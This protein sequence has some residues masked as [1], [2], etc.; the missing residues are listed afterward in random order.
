[1]MD[2]KQSFLSFLMV[3]VLAFMLPMNALGAPGNDA[4]QEP[5]YAK[6]GRI[7]VQEVKA[8]YPEDKVVDYLHV[9]RKT[10]D[11]E[12]IETFKLWLEG[13]TKEFGVVIDIHFDTDTEKI[14]NI[15]FKETSR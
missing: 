13:K 4:P 7:A 9:G 15:Q 6:W 3:M 2:K 11:Q 12:T 1:M 10:D 8:K 5:A 14:T